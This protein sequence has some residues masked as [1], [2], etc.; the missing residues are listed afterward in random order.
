M[1]RIFSLTALLLC[2]IMTLSAVGVSVSAVDFTGDDLIVIVLDPGHGTA[3]EPNEYNQSEGSYNMRTARY[4]KA[5]LDKNN[6][7]VVYMTNEAA[8]VDLS[9]YERAIFAD[10]VNADLMISVHYNS[11]PNPDLNGME[12]WSSVIPKFDTAALANMCV[13]YGVAAVPALLN[14]GVNQ[15]K[16]NAGFYWNEQYQWD[17]EGDPS[18]GVLSDYYGIITWGIKFGVPTFILEEIYLSN[19]HDRALATDANIKLIAEAQ[20]QA[21]IDYYTG[22]AH[23]Y[24]DVQTDIPLSCITKGK[25]SEHCTECGHRRNVSAIA[26]APDAEAHFYR[27]VIASDPDGAWT[28]VYTHSLI[29]KAK[30]EHEHHTGGG[31]QGVTPPNDT[32][33]S[34]DEPEPPEGEEHVHDFEVTGG[35]ERQFAVLTCTDC[36]EKKRIEPLSTY[37]CEANGHLLMAYSLFDGF[38]ALTA[39]DTVV[40]CEI[41]GKKF[42]FC[43]ACGAEE[44]DVTP[45][46][47][48]DYTVVN[49]V[50]ATCETIGKVEKLCNICAKVVIEDIPAVGHNFE[51]ETEVS[52][53]EEGKQTDRCTACGKENVVSL[54][55]A[56]HKYESS[57]K[58]EATA[59]EDG[60]REYVCSECG[61]SYTEPIPAK[62]NGGLSL[63]EGID[64]PLPIIAFIIVVILLVAAVIILPVVIRKKRDGEQVTVEAMDFT[65]TGVIDTEE[66]AEDGDAE[67]DAIPVAVDLDPIEHNDSEGDTDEDGD[68]AAVI[69]SEEDFIPED[70]VLVAEMSAEDAEQIVIADD[71]EFVID[72]ELVAEESAEDEMDSLVLEVIPETANALEEPEKACDHVTLGDIDLSDVSSEAGD[73]PSEEDL[74]A[75]K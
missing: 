17:I 59:N 37:D 68:I 55:P 75:S 53:A 3:G 23:T 66:K 58:S 2:V 4:I 67:T 65:T 70:E 62:G 51:R 6:S 32:N 57:V 40:S 34:P 33:N 22:H 30:L 5:A 8:S 10:S 9:H 54:P 13:E 7:F 49:E 64:L 11:S 45:A 42:S 21:I 26:D 38:E 61:H 16:D 44:Y 71:V 74:E 36:G 43:M 69:F 60:V 56:E 18:S 50:G 25:Q 72:D 39:E 52:C 47:G 31:M 14:G 19:E 41:D 27:P 46:Y 35:F 15:R 73:A 63:P 29:N 48:H 20:A 24:G 12:A 28:C 1:K